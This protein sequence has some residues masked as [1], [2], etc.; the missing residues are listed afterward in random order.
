MIIQE[1]TG[2]RCI[3]LEAVCIRVPGQPFTPCAGSFT[4]RHPSL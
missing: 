2:F 4:A 3:M 1:R